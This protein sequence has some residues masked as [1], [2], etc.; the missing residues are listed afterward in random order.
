M[1]LQEIPLAATGAVVCS[2]WSRNMDL[3][4]RY[5]RA[6]A[7]QLDQVAVWEPGEPAELGD[8]GVF[9]HDR[10]K[11]SGN[12]FREPTLVLPAA[13]AREATP[14]KWQGKRTLCGT[15]SL[16]TAGGVRTPVAR[17]SGTLSTSSAL[18]VVEVDSELRRLE[19]P[20]SLAEAVD[21]QVAEEWFARNLIVS[22]VHTARRFHVMVK[23]VETTECSVEADGEEIRAFLDG[24]R[25]EASLTGSGG[26]IVQNRTGPMSI[27]LVGFRRRYFS[28]RKDLRYFGASG[29]GD[30][31]EDCIPAMDLIREWG[32][33]P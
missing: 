7:E 6:F 9:E 31:P 22:Q 29:G 10:F 23:D 21:E 28:R 1:T 26:A 15:A 33:L 20:E 13:L 5:V 27:R 8:Y 2:V 30:A 3:W 16:G 18:F 4:R 19:S 14:A 17:A 12:V 32:L 24:L 11:R 25:V